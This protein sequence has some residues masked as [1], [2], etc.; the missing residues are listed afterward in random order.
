MK[1]GPRSAAGLRPS[2]PG[3]RHALCCTLGLAVGLFTG[4]VPG[5]ARAQP[6]LT[7]RCLGPVPESLRAAP[8]VDEAL[9]GLDPARL[10]DVHAHLLGTGDSGSGCSVSPEL[11]QWWRPLEVL[12]RRTILGAVCIDEAAGGIDRAYVARL[13]AL[14]DDFPAGSR[15]WLFAFDQAHDDDGRPAPQWTTFH[16]PDAYAQ[17]VAG[18][19]PQRFSWVASVHPYRDDAV[20]RVRQARQGG[21]VALK[22]LPSTQNI[23]LRDARC[24]ALYPE[25]A[26]LGLPLIVHCGEEK[27]AP[28]ARRDDLNNPLLLREPLAAGATVIAA[29]CASLGRARDLDRGGR[30]GGP[31]VAAFDLF[32]RLMDE[33]GHRGTLLGDLSALFQRNRRPAV[34]RA[35][36]ERSDWHGRLLHGSDHPLP[37]VTP[38]YAT[39]AFVREG[40]LD[41]ADEAPL[42]ALRDH[43]PLLFDL[44]LK[45]RLRLGA[46]RLPASVFEGR[47]LAA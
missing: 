3:R 12:R 14:A 22:W 36:L 2:F 16:V 10:T 34:W 24:R 37:G 19:A 29:H 20:A 39:A 30:A 44:V 42:Q 15:W 6:R 38:L 8:L 32:A 35:V 28:G 17:A 26:R 13:H 27:A 33:P 41:A 46:Q 47:A 21:A 1:P 11:Y 45:R 18:A 23:D 40:L 43:N 4:L 5:A 7:S 9:D 25:L 31:R